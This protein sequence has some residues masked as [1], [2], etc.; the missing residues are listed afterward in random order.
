MNPEAKKITTAKGRLKIVTARKVMSS[1]GER[2]ACVAP[3]GANSADQ[4]NSHAK[5]QADAG[6]IARTCFWI[7]TCNASTR[8]PAAAWMFP[9][10]NLASRTALTKIHSLEICSRGRRD[11]GFI[12][13]WAASY[14]GRLSM[15][16]LP[17]QTRFIAGTT[18]CRHGQR[19][20]NL[21]LPEPPRCRFRLAETQQRLL[22][23]HLGPLRT[24][25]GGVIETN[26]IEKGLNNRSAAGSAHRPP[27]AVL[28]LKH[29]TAQPQWLYRQP[30]KARRSTL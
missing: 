8:P 29:T 15:V 6:T 4:S 16:M 17:G 26:V 22:I 24:G 27:A 5:W 10:G 11:L 21:K 30:K 12:D 18:S 3:G 9:L 1:L 19:G 2:F 20:E 25:G 28:S 13:A 7:K 23:R 14:L